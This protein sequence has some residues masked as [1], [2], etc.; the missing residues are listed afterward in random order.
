ME[1]IQFSNAFIA[2]EMRKFVQVINLK[3]DNS[4][5]INIEIIVM[6]T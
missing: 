6:K 5:I 3:Q 4:I 2:N 1:I